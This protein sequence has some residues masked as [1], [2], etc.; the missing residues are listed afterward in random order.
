L[1]E[2][3][4]SDDMILLFSDPMHQI[5]NNES[6][7]MWQEKGKDGTLQMPSNTGRR[8]LN[9]L[10][11]INPITT[12]PTILLTEANCNKETA[13]VFL[14]QIR[15][16]YPDAEKIVIFL[17]NATYHRAYDVQD[18]AKALGIVLEYL[19]PY[20]PNLNLIERLWKFFKKKVVKNHYYPNFD[21]FFESTINFF[22]HFE[23]HH[24][25]LKLLLS[26]NFEII[27]AS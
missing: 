4:Q 12:K 11:A 23:N 26:P 24:E 9:I 25:E 20:S 8:R 15:S 18:E 14:K 5:H 3:E 10:G 7:Y 1:K 2:A 19:P 22:H 27:Q 6:G 17:D 21:E 13:K 16:D